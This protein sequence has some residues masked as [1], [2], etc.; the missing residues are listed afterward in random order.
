MD[1]YEHTTT[2]EDDKILKMEKQK[3]KQ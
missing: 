3:K 2:D 1:G